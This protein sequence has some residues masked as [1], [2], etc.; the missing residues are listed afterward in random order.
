MSVKKEI[1]DENRTKCLKQKE[2]DFL[3][4]SP[5]HIICIGQQK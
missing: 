2:F 4:T 1:D 3:A 5:A